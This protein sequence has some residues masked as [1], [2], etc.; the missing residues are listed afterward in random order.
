MVVVRATKALNSGVMLEAD[1]G[2]YN[3][4]FSLYQKYSCFSQVSPHALG[5][6]RLTLVA[7]HFISES[8]D[9]KSTES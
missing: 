9:N 2:D 3:R 7:M 5:S 1:G 8:A 6:S 4:H